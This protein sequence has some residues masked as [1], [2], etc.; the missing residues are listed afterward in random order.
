MDFSHYFNLRNGEEN[1]T[2]V[3]ENIVTNTS[4][5]GWK[6]WI[7]A[8]AIIIVSIGLNVN[9]TAVIIGAMLISPLMGPIVGAGFSLGTQNSDLLQKSLKNLWIA[10]IV[11]L[12]VSAMYFFL[13]PFKDP[14]SELLA[15][16]APN[17][18]DVLV[19]FFWGVV[20]AI[21]VTRVEKWNPI[22]WVA[23]ATALMPPL[24]TA[25]YGIGIGSFQFFF[26]GM[27]LYLI[28]CVFI[29]IATFWVVKY[30]HYPL[31]QRP[32]MAKQRRIGIVISTVMIIMILP[33]IYFA[34]DLFQEKKYYQEAN[35]FMQQEFSDQWYTIIYKK[36]TFKKS[37]KIE[38]AVLT[39]KF[40]ETE[41]KRLTEKLNNYGLANTQLI[42]KQDST[43][44]K[45][46]ILKEIGKTDKTINEKNLVIAQLQQKLDEYNFDI[47][48]LTSEM[49][50]L[51]PE[52]K[53]ISIAQHTFITP[54]EDSEEY[55]SEIVPVMV[56]ESN[57]S[58]SETEKEKIV[59]WLA[60]RL[61]VEKV[62]IVQEGTPEKTSLVLKSEQ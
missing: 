20:G 9:S 12:F 31:V 2:E 41:I 13:S 21:A 48:Q 35:Q 34:Y 54:V 37:K 42:I 62:K 7:L 6:I 52:I 59:Q 56:Y 1:K 8:C 43:D 33:S 50:I 51:F 24:C 38:I 36:L 60:E 30:L 19:A 23:I 39:K 14:Q 40:S 46:D 11:S 10:T 3:L 22:P 16:S 32:N 57:V 61:R 17:I 55:T 25:W 53:N 26:G 49:R 18:Y 15:R 44:L 27:Y 4:F 28:N 5:Q 45:S 58:I 47:P 29:C